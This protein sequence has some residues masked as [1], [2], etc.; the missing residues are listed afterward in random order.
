MNSPESMY[1]SGKSAGVPQ[2]VVPPQG[3]VKKVCALHAFAGKSQGLRSTNHRDRLLARDS[4]AFAIEIRRA[5]SQS[6]K[7]MGQR[8]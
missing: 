4:I 6:A 5:S 3:S 2:Q 7:G 1:R 8:S